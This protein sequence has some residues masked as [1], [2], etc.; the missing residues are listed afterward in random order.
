MHE[1]F[2]FF[3]ILSYTS[4]HNFS[5]FLKDQLDRRGGGGG[6][7]GGGKSVWTPSSNTLELEERVT[8]LL[9]K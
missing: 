3:A 8:N 2:W 6:G 4:K 9:L 1:T 5:F 7:G